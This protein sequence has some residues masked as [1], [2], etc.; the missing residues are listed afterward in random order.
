MHDDRALVEDRL[1]HLIERLEER[2]HRVVAE[3][4]EVVPA[5]REFSL[6]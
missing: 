4:D 3:L 6:V 5:Q 2:T 1:E